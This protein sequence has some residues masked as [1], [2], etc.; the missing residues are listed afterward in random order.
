MGARLIAATVT[1]ACLVPAAFAATASAET[2]ASG[3][4]WAGGSAYLAMDLAS[5]ADSCELVASVPGRTSQVL[6][7]VKPS[8]SRVAWVWKV[9]VRARTANW[10]VSATCGSSN[11]S[12]SYI[13]HGPRRRSVLSLARQIRVLQYGGSFPAAAQLQLTVVQDIARTWWVRTATSILSQFHAGIAT[14]QCT[15]YVAAKRP[16]VIQTVDIWAYTKFLLAHGGPLG[17]N[18]TARDWA[19]NA[20]SAGLSTGRVPEAGAVMVFQPGAY[21]AHS[22]GHVAIVDS[23]HGD[24]GFTI[25]EMHAPV[26]G[27]VSTR[28][29]SAATALAMLSNPQIGFI[30]R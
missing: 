6:S 18:W 27:Q 30:Y 13:V 15:D 28:N 14:G 17:V 8:Q 3:S 24:G 7:A 19:A 10:R 5:P 12:A 11:L 20:Q 29:F 1:F 4:L 26:I 21:G 23:V 16:D 22:D 2:V 25:S 9:P